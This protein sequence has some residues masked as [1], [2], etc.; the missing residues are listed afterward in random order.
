MASLRG[1]DLRV[2]HGPRAVQRV[3]L[4]RRDGGYAHVVEEVA[5]GQC[6]DIGGEEVR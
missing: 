2:R 6:E 4:W 5:E 3:E 1:I